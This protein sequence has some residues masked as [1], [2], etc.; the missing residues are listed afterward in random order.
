MYI[1]ASGTNIKYT[2][3]LARKKK[4]FQQKMEWVFRR[5]IHHVKGDGIYAK[6]K[7]DRDKEYSGCLTKTDTEQLH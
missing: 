7:T 6:Q 3:K 4:N 1:Y 2:Q 5:G